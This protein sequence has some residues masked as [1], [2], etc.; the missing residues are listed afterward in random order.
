MCDDQVESGTTCGIDMLSCGVDHKS[1]A[2]RYHWP[3]M[4]SQAQMLCEYRSIS[5]LQVESVRMRD[6]QGQSRGLNRS[7]PY[8]LTIDCAASK[9]DKA[10]HPTQPVSKSAS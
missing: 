3:E 2:P 4:L 1:T 9:W 8:K 6:S 5:G 7:P 10:F